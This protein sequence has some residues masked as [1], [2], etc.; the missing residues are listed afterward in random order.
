[1]DAGVA[2]DAAARIDVELALAHSL[3]HGTASIAKFL[4]T[5]AV[6]I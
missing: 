4:P 3:I 5:D 2:A 1:L 6:P